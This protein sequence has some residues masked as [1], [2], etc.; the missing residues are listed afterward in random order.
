M[1]KG[2]A[3]TIYNPGFPLKN[4]IWQCPPP[5]GRIIDIFF[6]PVDFWIP[7]NFLQNQIC[8]THADGQ[9]SVNWAHPL[10]WELH[11]R[12]KQFYF[13]GGRGPASPD[14]P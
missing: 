13:R 8:R 2:W 5:A 4:L 1:G 12:A 11:F 10:H 3:R 9:W 6:P 7:Q 14:I